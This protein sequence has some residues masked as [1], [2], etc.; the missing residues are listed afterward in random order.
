MGIGSSS[1]LEEHLSEEASHRH[2]SGKQKPLFGTS[3]GTE[4]DVASPYVAH[5]GSQS[6]HKLAISEQDLKPKVS[7]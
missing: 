7:W 3:I 5:I 4:A 2:D 6:Q 1:A